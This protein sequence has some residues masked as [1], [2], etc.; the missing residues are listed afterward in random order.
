MW[1][2]T[3]RDGIELN[4][5][6]KSDK[7]RGHFWLTCESPWSNRSIGNKRHLLMSELP[8]TI[9]TVAGYR[10]TVCQ[11]KAWDK[12]LSIIRNE[13]NEKVLKATQ[14][15]EA[16]VEGVGLLVTDLKFKDFELL[17]DLILS[18]SGW[19]R[20]AK[21]G[22]V[23]EAIDIEAENVAIDEI[24]FVQVKSSATQAVFD[25]SLANFNNQRERFHRMIFAVHSPKGILTPPKEQPVSIWTSKEIANRVVRLGLGDWVA[26][27]L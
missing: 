22:G 4:P 27:R 5:N 17:I 9:T 12:I 15:R 3:V 14:A 11:P 19:A 21:L 18:R 26:S 20:L 24:A 1:W 7:K 16:Y 2:C 13:E 10:A 23:T 8:G 6:G 25:D